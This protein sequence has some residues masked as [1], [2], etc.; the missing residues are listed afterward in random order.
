MLLPLCKINFN[1]TSSINLFLLT[2][3]RLFTVSESSGNS[4]PAIS[5]AAV[6]LLQATTLPVISALD[7][8][9]LIERELTKTDSLPPVTTASCSVIDRTSS[10]VGPSGCDLDTM[11]ESNKISEERCP[12][13]TS[14]NNDSASDNCNWEKFGAAGCSLPKVMQSSLGAERRLCYKLDPAAD[15]VKSDQIGGCP[16]FDGAVQAVP[17]CRLASGPPPD[18]T[19]LAAHRLSSSS[20][21]EINNNCR[22]NFSRSTHSAKAGATATKVRRRGAASAV[23]KSKR[24]NRGRRYNEM[25]SQNHLARKRSESSM[26]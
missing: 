23:R 13:H 2:I 8:H 4:S 22:Q 9:M 14:P 24:C 17:S 18:S 15:V 7:V 25:M 21:S 10:A 5:S 1:N 19:P 6:R 12:V 20:L 3:G 11:S 16:S 26:P